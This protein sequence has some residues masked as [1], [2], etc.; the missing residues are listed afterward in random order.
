M[1]IVNAQMSHL[2]NAWKHGSDVQRVP[3]RMAL[4]SADGAA[5]SGEQPDPAYWTAYDFHM[6]ERDA[7]AMRR[8][9]MYSMIAT[10]GIRLSQLIANG[11]RVLSRKHRQPS[12]SVTS[13]R[14]DGLTPSLPSQRHGA[15]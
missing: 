10:H 14:A 7:R 8:A 12:V 13:D 9:R 11:A 2:L 5:R 4:P 3:T 6:I 15:A 1:G